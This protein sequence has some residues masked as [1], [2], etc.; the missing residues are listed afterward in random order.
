MNPNDQA[1]Q[2]NLLTLVEQGLMKI[3][4]KDADT[5]E[6]LFSLTKKGKKEA[7]RMIKEGK[8]KRN[9]GNA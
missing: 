8:Q 9:S 3:T 2:K 5:G 7:E 6:L 4:G 1:V